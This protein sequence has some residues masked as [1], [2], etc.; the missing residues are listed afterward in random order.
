ADTSAP[1]RSPTTNPRAIRAATS[2]RPR[3]GHSD[4]PRVPSATA[5]TSGGGGLAR[6]SSV[7]GARHSGGGGASPGTPAV[8]SG[9]GSPIPRVEPRSGAPP[10]PGPSGKEWAV[11][12]L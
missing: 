5:G 12:L 4:L 1:P 7:L 2:A 11:Q 6:G 8:G 3:G 9:E 10:G